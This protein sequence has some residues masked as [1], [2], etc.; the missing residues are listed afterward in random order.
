MRFTTLSTAICA[1]MLA[2]GG[3]QAE[4]PAL[5]GAELAAWQTAFAEIKG[6]SPKWAIQGADAFHASSSAGVPVVYL[7]VR[8]PEERE[9]GTVEGAIEVSLT[10]LATEAGLAA[11]PE[12]KNAIMA[13]YCKSGHR[14]ALAIPLLHRLGYANATSMQGGYEGW[15]EAGFPVSN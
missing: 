6:M 12:D 9:K 3:A 7:D 15:V 1:M 10:E 4:M 8:T 5:D 14:S 11:L 13:V 2:A